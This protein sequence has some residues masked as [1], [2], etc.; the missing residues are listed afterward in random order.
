MVLLDLRERR[1]P[2]G[3]VAPQTV[4]STV[5]PQPARMVAI[6]GRSL[7]MFVGNMPPR[8][9]P[10]APPRP[11]RRL[12][13]LARGRWLRHQNGARRRCWCCPAL[14]SARPLSCNTEHHVTATY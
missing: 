11:R 3:T 6:L 14:K 13:L 10:V 9:V 7:W 5:P 4:L 8:L 12:L 2:V 1:S